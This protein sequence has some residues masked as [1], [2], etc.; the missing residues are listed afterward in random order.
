MFMDVPDTIK[1]DALEII[2]TKFSWELREGVTYSFVYD[3]E[4]FVALKQ[5]VVE[6]SEK[7]IFQRM[8]ERDYDSISSEYY[9]TEF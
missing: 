9:N 2:G 5:P 7:I 6:G 4:K 8:A 3:S 1:G